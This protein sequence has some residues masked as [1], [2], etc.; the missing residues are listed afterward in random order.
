M[1]ARCVTIGTTMEGV[2]DYMNGF[3]AGDTPTL[4]PPVPIEAATRE[5][6]TQLVAAITLGSTPEE[7]AGYLDDGFPDEVGLLLARPLE[8]E[9]MSAHVDLLLGAMQST[10]LRKAA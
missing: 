4:T 7:I 8:A 9:E 3:D 5:R 2:D 1:T 10:P 6:L